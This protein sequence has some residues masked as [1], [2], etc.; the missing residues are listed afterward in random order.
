MPPE[1]RWD[2]GSD[3]IVLAPEQRPCSVPT[4]KG[5]SGTLGQSEERVG[6]RMGAGVGVGQS[7]V[8]RCVVRFPLREFFVA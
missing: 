6:K 5:G 2:K 8:E 1:P 4:L 3:T 7:A